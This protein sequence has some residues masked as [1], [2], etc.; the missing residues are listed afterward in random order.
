MEFHHTIFS[1]FECLE[2]FIANMYLITFFFGKKRVSYVKGIWC[3]EERIGDI[4]S[5]YKD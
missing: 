5:L 3:T 2:I 1:T 4:Q